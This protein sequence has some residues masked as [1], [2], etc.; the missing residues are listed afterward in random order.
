[1]FSETVV[2]SAQTMHISCTDT[3]T[4]SKRTQN[5]VPHNP[6]HLGVLSGVFKMIFEPVVRSVQTVH[7]SCV[8]LSTMFKWTKTSIH[9]SLVTCKYHWGRPKRFLSYVWCKPCTYLAMTLTLSTT[10]LERDNTS[11][12]SPSRSIGCVQND[13]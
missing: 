13:F 2:C 7:L 12:I 9:P 4:V 5:M 3:N 8:K 1:M 6:R 10:R 11:P